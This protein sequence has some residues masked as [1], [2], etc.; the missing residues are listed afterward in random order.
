MSILASSSY[1]NGMFDWPSAS[2]VS[3]Q[4]ST[5]DRQ[6]TEYTRGRGG[7]ESYV[8]CDMRFQPI[9]GAFVSMVAVVAA[10]A[11]RVGLKGLTVGFLKLDE[12]A[13]WTAE[14]CLT[15]V[16]LMAKDEELVYKE[17]CV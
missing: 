2:A 5:F 7:F 4:V 6:L 13:A 1:G 17:C 11:N 10:V 14:M 12:S 16:D 8:V 3:K 15:V 9:E